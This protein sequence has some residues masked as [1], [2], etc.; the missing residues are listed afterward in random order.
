MRANLSLTGGLM[1][2]EAV[3]L[4]LAKRM[5]DAARRRM[6]SEFS[7]EKMVGRHVELYRELLG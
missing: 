3:M 6:L 7:V 1:G 4:E 2:S 5:G